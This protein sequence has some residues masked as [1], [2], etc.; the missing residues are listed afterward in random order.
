MATELK[1]EGVAFLLGAKAKGF[2]EKH[3]LFMAES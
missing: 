1:A 2:I 3:Y